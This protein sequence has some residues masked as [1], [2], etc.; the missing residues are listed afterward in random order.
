MLSLL[1]RYVL[2]VGGTTLQIAASILL[3]LVPAATVA[4]DLVNWAV[5]HVIPPRVLPKLDF[6]DGVPADCRTMVVV[7]VLLTDAAEV[8]ALLRQLEL[9]FL[10]NTDSQVHFALLT[11][12]SDAPHQH[13]PDD[14]ALLE[15]IRSG[16]EALN[17]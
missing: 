14:D 17:Q 7:P 4:I 13:M 2:E 1:A 15:Q 6:R 12:F 9:H 8:E 16:I 3:V 11:D 10:G 5:T